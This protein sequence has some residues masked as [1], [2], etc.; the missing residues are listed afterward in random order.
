[1]ASLPYIPEPRQVNYLALLFK[2]CRTV[3]KSR[4]AE[5]FLVTCFYA[6]DLFL[7]KKFNNLK[8]FDSLFSHERWQTCFSFVVS[9]CC[10]FNE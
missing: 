4:R 7:E 3:V 6:R 1:M 10:H 8:I 9:L 2:P 5:R